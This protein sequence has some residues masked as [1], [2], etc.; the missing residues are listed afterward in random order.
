M[1]DLGPI[2]KN[3][4]P[5]GIILDIDQLRTRPKKPRRKKSDR[6]QPKMKRNK[7]R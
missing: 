2:V 4:A 5:A 1:K 3:K 6:D 7:K